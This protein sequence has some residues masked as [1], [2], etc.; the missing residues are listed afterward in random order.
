MMASQSPQTARLTGKGCFVA[1]APLRDPLH[2]TFLRSPVAAGRIAILD[3]AEAMVLPDVHAVH[4]GDDVAHLG[5]LSVNDVIP[6]ETPL[7]FPILAQDTVK[8]VGQPI[9]AVLAR[10]D[11]AGLDAVETMLLDIEETDLPDPQTIATQHWQTGD[12]AAAFARADTIVEATISHSRLAPSPMEPRGIAVAYD[13]AR[14]RLTIWHAT[15]TP[16]RTRSELARILAIDPARIRV[17]ARDVGGAFGMKASLYPE[18]VFA[19][20]AALHHRADVRWIATRGED[21]LSATQGRGLHTQGALAL[22]SAGRFL[23]LRATVT[24]PVGHWLPNSALIPA[25]NGARILPSGYA[26][27]TVDITTRAQSTPFAP[28][29]IYRG[30]GRPEANALMERLVDKAARALGRDPLEIRRQNLI[31]SAQLPYVTATR[32]TLD[33]GD[34]A[35]ALDLLQSQSDLAALRAEQTRRRAAG[36]VVGIGLAFYL[37][38]SGSGWESARVVL[39]PDGRAEIASGSSS[40]GQ[41]RRDSY[42][43][44]AAKTLDIDPEHI[45]VTLGDTGTCPAG[46]GALASRATAIGGSAVAEACRKARTQRDAG[47]TGM[48]TVDEVYENRGQAWGHGAC[49]VSLSIDPETGKPTLEKVICVDDAGTIINHD[50][51][52][53]QIT[54]GFAQGLGE[55]LMEAVHYDEEGQLLTGSFMDYALP[56]AADMPAVDIHALCSPSPMNVLGAK[57]LGEAGTISAPIAILNAVLDALAPLGIEDLDMPLTPSMLWHAMT[58]AQQR[59]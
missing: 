55:A 46:I 40:Q 47:E 44:I 5:A 2:V 10:S 22:D 57:G 28:V 17:I 36:E 51:A 1:D 3:G 35:A 39:H 30:A 38:P 37:E 12:C 8:A 59:T 20:W 48:I 34:Y 58:T 49:L 43:T 4:T 53:G 45:T 33:S 15:Q 27:D 41:S 26:I 52:M 18:E 11:A 23:A 25:W 9:A 7:P 56:R 42:R 6:Q 29:G 32:N 50:A 24:A 31:P 13:P 14:D 19:V 54:G 16:H 21:F